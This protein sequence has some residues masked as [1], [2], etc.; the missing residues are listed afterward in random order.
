MKM[1]GNTPKVYDLFHPTPV[2]LKELAAIAVSLQ[3]WRSE[4]KKFR[5]NGIKEKFDPS[6]HATCIS[7]DTYLP[8]LP[9]CIHDVIDG[10]VKKLGLSIDSWVSDHCGK[11]IDTNTN[12]RDFSSGDFYYVLKYF[13]DFVCDYDGTL[14]YARTAKRWL[15]CTSNMLGLNGKFS[16]ACLYCF[17]DVIKEVWP[18]VS[19]NTVWNDIKCDRNPIL[20]YWICYLRNDLG[21]IKNR[22]GDSVYETMFC[23]IGKDKPCLRPAVDY[24]WDRI[25]LAGRMRPAKKVMKYRFKSFVRFLLPKLDN[26]LLQ[27]I[28]DYKG[29]DLVHILFR[30]EK[31]DEQAVITTWLYVRNRFN[32]DMFSYLVHKIFET[33][34]LYVSDDFWGTA[35]EDDS[36]AYLA[37]EIWNNAPHKLK[38]L[39]IRNIIS[40]GQMF[41]GMADGLDWD[42]DP[43]NADFLLTVIS[44]AAI[45][46]RKN[47]FWLRNWHQLIALYSGKD[48]HQM[49][50]L[51]F[52][53]DDKIVR[54]KE[55]VM[56]VSK[57]VSGHCRKLLSYSLFNKL[58]DFI[59]FLYP[60]TQP[61]INFK[62][63]ILKSAYLLTDFTEENALASSD[64]LRRRFFELLNRAEFDEVNDFLNFLWPEMRE[65]RIFK[66]RL[67]QL[68]FLGQDCQLGDSIM[69]G[70]EKFNGFIDDTFNTVELSNDFKNQLASSPSIQDRLV[71]YAQSSYD[72]EKFLKFVDTFVLQEQTLMQIKRRTGDA[73]KEH[74]SKTNSSDKYELRL[75]FSYDFPSDE[76]LLWCFGNEEEV[77]KFK[78]SIGYKPKDSSDPMLVDSDSDFELFPKIF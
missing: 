48:L 49:M 39:T 69:R 5:T 14:H 56:A 46:D 66:Q 78:L 50:K 32:K 57:F 67:L 70:I 22:R 71:G 42:P 3:I 59:S 40:D 11:V 58:K 37:R 47:L 6:E 43:K 31:Y 21:K 55:K 65:P 60:E 27:E 75:R 2:P 62:R 64:K 63:K 4:L 53:N 54:F 73:L 52:E 38:L 7:L 34:L 35:R 20:Y 44:D 15:Q 26:Q 77:A 28:I 25:P 72:I 51:C 76:F 10:Y 68:A 23:L 1:A 30:D 74:F 17:E 16:I 8:D 24:F 29:V 36:L 18:F 33:E 9:T 61:A 41:Q 13:D 12:P 45:K 19:K